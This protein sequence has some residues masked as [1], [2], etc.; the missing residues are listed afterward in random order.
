MADALGEA[1]WDYY[2]NPDTKAKLWIHNKYGPKEEM[3]VDV[4]FRGEEDMPKLELAAIDA[5]Y[6]KV[7]D[8]GAGAGS[9]ALLLQQ[10]GF[11][12]TAMDI[13]PKAADVMHLRGVHKIIIADIFTYNAK[14]FD[15]V[16]LLMNG[17][18]LSANIQTLRTF[19]QHAKTLINPGGQLLFDSSDIAYLYEGNIPT[20]NYYGEIMYEY[21]YKGNSSGWFSW[22]YIDKKTLTKVAAE[23]GWQTTILATDSFDGYLASLALR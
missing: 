6:G 20:G 12:V 14:R 5:C 17:I 22:L 8:V 3:P 7:L 19:L 23:E 16:L 18:G 9:H 4:Y 11:N 10:K 21:R 1:L 13:S 15:T 2:H